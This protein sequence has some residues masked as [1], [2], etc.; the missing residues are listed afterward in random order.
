MKHAFRIY[1][2]QSSS[3]NYGMT[4][5]QATITR[6]IDID[7]FYVGVNE[8]NIVLPRQ[9]TANTAITA[10]IMDCI[11]SNSGAFFGV[12]MQMEHSQLSH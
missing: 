7:H 10:L 12:V 11:D 8:T 4:Q 5:H 3:F 6:K 9:F 1:L 2:I